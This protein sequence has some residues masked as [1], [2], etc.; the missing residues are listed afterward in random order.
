MVTIL[1]YGGATSL[2]VWL[3]GVSGAFGPTVN[4]TALV[5][6]VALIALG[7]IPPGGP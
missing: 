5:V 2:A 3:A 1:R 7:R 4:W 6:G